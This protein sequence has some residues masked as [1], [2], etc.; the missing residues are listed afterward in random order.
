MNGGKRRHVN[1]KNS[2]GYTILEVMIVLA[3]SGV[4]FVIAA[5]FISGK[6]GRTQFTEGVNE[7]ASTLQDTVEGVTD[8]QYTD[9]DLKCTFF[10]A[11]PPTS[12]TTTIGT[13]GSLDH[14]GNQA[15]CVFLGK[16]LHFRE[17]NGHGDPEKQQY[18]VFSIAGGRVGSDNKPIT[19]LDEAGPT[20]IDTLTSQETVPQRLDIENIQVD[21]PSGQVTSYGIGFMQGQ[22][23]KSITGDTQNGAQSLG[24]YYVEGLSYGKNTPN[25]AGQVTG[26]NLKPANKIRLCVTDGTRSAYITLGANGNHL[27]VDVEMRGDVVC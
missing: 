5:N 26:A 22:G 13:A 19:N 23:S 8:G 2:L 15:P 7:L 14:Q 12:S 6:Q 20:V 1:A 4:M 3:V 21:T 24:L 10:A 11:S 16:V 9:I 18:E 17:D 27:G 25:A